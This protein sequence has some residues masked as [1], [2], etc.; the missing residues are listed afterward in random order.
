M[1]RVTSYCLVAAVTVAAATIVACSSGPSAFEP[2]KMAPSSIA[3][4]S[5]THLTQR[6][7]ENRSGELALTV[8][9]TQN[10]SVAAYTINAKG[11]ALTMVEGA[12]YG[13]GGGSYP[14]SLAVDRKR[15]FLYVAQAG[16]GHN[17]INAFT[18]NAVTGVL[19]PIAGSPFLIP[20]PFDSA[21]GV[22]VDP[23]GKFVYVSALCNTGCDESGP[24]TT[25]GLVAAFTINA[26][27]GALTPVTGSP[28][29]TRGY[30]SS[31]VVV[32][33]TG[34]FVYV[35]N[36]TFNNIKSGSVAA[37][38]INAKSGALKEVATSPFVTGGTCP[39]PA[40]LTID[41]RGEF[42]YVPNI[43]S[44]NVSAFT[45]NADSG[46]LKKVARSPFAA[47][48]QPIS[49]AVDPTGEFAYV[50]NYQSNDAYIY[51]VNAKNGALKRVGT[52]VSLPPSCYPF[53]VALNRTGKFLYVTCEAFNNILGFTV[54]ATS[55]EL[56][57]MA[58]SP[59]A[60]E[61]TEPG[62]IIITSLK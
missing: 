53:S 10:G 26:S 49:V 19:T 39:G 25:M 54:N 7:G 3:F 45:I 34:K 38:T 57:P 62:Q 16:N 37:Y 22:A 32:D 15:G 31:G 50:V 8:N 12:P 5:Q 13:L 48:T 21:T 40:G 27:S 30:Y 55:G 35:S 23:M 58:Q 2:G 20:P 6:V 29:R 28:F 36:G 44:N 42:L 56:T 17:G 14:A 1:A 9:D 41:P 61:G 51:S 46:A 11:G 24:K 4:D 52:P 60:T 47:G 59:W 43:C 33:P 18:I